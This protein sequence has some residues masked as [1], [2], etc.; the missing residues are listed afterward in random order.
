MRPNLGKPFSYGR[1][2]PACHRSIKPGSLRR[3]RGWDFHKTARG[4]HAIMAMGVPLGPNKLRSGLDLTPRAEH[5][6]VGPVKSPVQNSPGRP[7]RT[8]VRAY[9][10]PST[11]AP[12]RKGVGGR[13]EVMIPALV[14]A[15]AARL[16]D[17]HRRWT[18][19]LEE[20]ERTG[21]GV[22]ARNTLIRR[23]MKY[24]AVQNSAQVA[25]GRA[26]RGRPARASKTRGGGA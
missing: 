26:A 18:A 3:V 9:A 14:I 19:V 7:Q 13:P 22:W 4:E 12:S 20:L 25:G 2:C 11:S 10:A 5:T 1:R 15:R 16:Y 17:R 6:I 8:R 23:V 24:S 21:N